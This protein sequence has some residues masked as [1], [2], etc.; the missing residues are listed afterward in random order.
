VLYATINWLESLFLCLFLSFED[1]ISFAPQM[2]TSGQIRAG[3]ALLG[4][5]QAVLA[6]R[7]ILSLSALIRLENGK[8]DAR[9]ST[10]LAIQEALEKGGIEFIAETDRRGPGVRL[11]SPA[12]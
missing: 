3:R 5:S 1:C 7:A 8:S 6:D 10:V 4:W 9:S 11:A 12:E 2:I